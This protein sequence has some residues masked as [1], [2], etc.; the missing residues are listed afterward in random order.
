MANYIHYNTGYVII[1]GTINKRL[2]CNLSHLYS[3]KTKCLD[4]Q[5]G[6]AHISSKAFKRALGSSCAENF[7]LKFMHD[8][9]IHHAYYSYTY[10][11]WLL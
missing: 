2:A 5:L 4:I 6:M 9:I 8:V 7:S 11:A 3:S 1:S 10:M